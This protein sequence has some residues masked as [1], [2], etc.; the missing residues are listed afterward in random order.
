MHLFWLTK[1]WAQ[2]QR[3]ARLV[4]WGC[5][6]EEH[7]FI[8]ITALFRCLPYSPVTFHLAL[9]FP[10]KRC[11]VTACRQ[12][13]VACE[14]VLG[15]VGRSQFPHCSIRRAGISFTHTT[16][17]PPY[18]NQSPSG[19]SVC[20]PARNP[21]FLNQPVFCPSLVNLKP[22]CL[23]RCLQ[24][25]PRPLSGREAACSTQPVGVSVFVQKRESVVEMWRKWRRE[26]VM[27]IFMYTCTFL[28]A[29]FIYSPYFYAG[30]ISHLTFMCQ[31]FRRVSVIQ[32]S[33]NVETFIP[34]DLRETVATF[35][36][37]CS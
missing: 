12:R 17:H 20:L 16:E 1:L 33:L 36:R 10:W 24:A 35:P 2:S 14:W 19:P 4:S 21:R 8:I 13:V 28:H 7:S 29:H 30:S 25:N 15:G 11:G 32:H 9:G 34:V 22:K 5:E 6:N 18:C 31:L 37:L 26:C 3:L 27:Y 23:L